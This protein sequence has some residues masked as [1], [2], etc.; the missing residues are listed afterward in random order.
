[1]G[2]FLTPSV[3]SQLSIDSKGRKLT[4]DV[5]DCTYEFVSYLFSGK[6]SLQI[7]SKLNEFDDRLSFSVGQP[8]RG[9]V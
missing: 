7:T 1:M 4:N 9:I 8:K 5:Y 3:V 6:S 2:L